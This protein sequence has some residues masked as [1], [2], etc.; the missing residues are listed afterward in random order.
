MNLLAFL[1]NFPYFLKENNYS[2][3]C[4]VGKK[5]PPLFFYFLKGLLKQKCS[6]MTLSI[7]NKEL[8]NQE[9]MSCL[10]SSLLYWCPAI[11]EGTSQEKEDFLHF[12]TTYKGP[13]IISFFI[14]SEDKFKPSQEML[15]IELEEI[16]DK[17]LYKKLYACFLDNAINER[18]VEDCFNA[19]SKIFLDN[20]C[21]LMM[22]QGL[23]G[24]KHQEFVIH[25]LGRLLPQQNSLF[26]LSGYFLGYQEKLFWSAWYVQKDF[27]PP[28]FWSNFFLELV[29]QALLFI[30]LARKTSVVEAKK[31]ASRLPFSFI[32]KHWHMHN[33]N[34][35]RSAHSFLYQFD[36]RLKN[37]IANMGALD[38]F[39]HKFMTKQF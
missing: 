22:Y 3:W 19:F 5:Y 36:Y 23:L 28:E 38:L 6:I 25:W 20:A 2:V 16:I 33:L 18:F 10:G 24:K 4:F 14:N 31:Q 34:H 26:Q 39:M 9:I 35:L 1:S 8:Y 29:W 21:L 32:Q 17:N 13:H 7:F 30:N 27:Y 37:G 15:V 12:I 11:M